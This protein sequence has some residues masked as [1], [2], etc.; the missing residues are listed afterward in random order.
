MSRPSPQELQHN[1][2]A[3]NAT[4][5]RLALFRLHE[6]LHRL[7]EHVQTRYADAGDETLLETLADANRTLAHAEQ[8]AEERHLMLT[9]RWP[10]CSRCHGDGQ[11]TQRGVLLQRIP[12]PNC[13]GTGS[14]LSADAPP[15]PPALPRGRWQRHIL[16][17]L[18][19]LGGAC[20][21]ISL[22]RL[23]GNHRPSSSERAAFSRAL[24]ILEQRDL[25]RRTNDQALTPRSAVRRAAH[26]Q[27]SPTG[28]ALAHTL[29]IT[30]KR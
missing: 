14:C 9:A 3:E 6:A 28:T 21:A 15:S 30:S 2:L 11:I 18:L 17:R 4:T 7:N 23:W 20:W 8:Q 27:L 12:C 24:R 25:L 16:T 19:A 22:K 13:E 1:V 26:I 29:T 5:L 10:A